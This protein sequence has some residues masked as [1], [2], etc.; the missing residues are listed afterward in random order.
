MSTITAYTTTVD[1]YAVQATWPSMGIA[2]T[3]TAVDFI[4]YPVKTVQGAGTIG[5][6]TV[7]VQGS[8]D[9]TNWETL[10]D[11][12]G[13]AISKTATFLVSIRENPRFIRVSTSGG[14]GTNFTVTLMG[15]DAG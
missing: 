3:G 15:V 4:R 7:V 6:A 1:K 10:T 13:T 12:G 5:G 11:A 2:D 8:N 9:G 14:A